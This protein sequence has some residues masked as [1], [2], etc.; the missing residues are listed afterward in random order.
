MSQV[1]QPEFMAFVVGRGEIAYQREDGI[2]V[3]PIA[4]LGA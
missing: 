2:F 4:T 1:R 3:L